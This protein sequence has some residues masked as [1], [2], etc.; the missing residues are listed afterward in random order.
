MSGDEQDREKDNT[1]LAEDVVLTQYEQTYNSLR[2]HD[3]L[4]WQTPS[5]AA[6]INSGI[7]LVAFR[8]ITDPF[9]RSGLIFVGVLLTMSLALALVKHRY[10]MKIE[11]ESLEKIENNV[12]TKHIQRQTSPEKKNDYWISRRPGN[13]FEA[14]SASRGLIW[15]MFISVLVLLLLFL[16]SF[17]WNMASSALPL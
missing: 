2:N 8:F 15:G 13:A 6:A 1:R 12:D 3:N 11:T 16:Y 9:V 5:V 7:L 10:F 17:P 4:L 14:L